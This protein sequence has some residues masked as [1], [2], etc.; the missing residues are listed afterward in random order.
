MAYVEQ[1]VLR[2][3][4]WALLSGRG[5]FSFAHHD[6]SGLATWV[7]IKLGTKI[8]CYLQ[9]RS[10]DVK[11]VTDLVE[12]TQDDTRMADLATP[13]ILVLTENTIL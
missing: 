12:N 5:A 3:M 1:D 7:T 8:W 10:K 6:A 9:P 13:N 4:S 11:A 2:L